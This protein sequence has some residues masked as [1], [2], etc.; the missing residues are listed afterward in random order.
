MKDDFRHEW[1]VF[2][3]TTEQYFDDG[4]PL[5]SDNMAP[6]DDG[7]PA[8]NFESSTDLQTAE[9]ATQMWLNEKKNE[10]AAWATSA[11]VFDK[12]KLPG[13]IGQIV[14]EY[15]TY[16]E[17]DPVAV[18][19]TIM[20]QLSALLSYEG[21]PF[22][23]VNNRPMRPNLYTLILGDTALGRKGTSYENAQQLMSM[24]P[25][26]TI[27]HNGVDSGEG[28]IS[29]LS[30]AEDETHEDMQ[31]TKQVFVHF[32][33]Y[34]TFMGKGRAEGSTLHNHLRTAWSGKSL[35]N[36]TRDK[37]L[38]ARDYSLSVVGH[39]TYRELRNLLG[40][41]DIYGGSLNRNILVHS[42]RSKKLPN[43]PYL[44]R[45]LLALWQTEINGA[46]NRAMNLPVVLD[47]YPIVRSDA[48]S[49]AWVKIYEDDS[50]N[51]ETEAVRAATN[52]ILVQEQKMQLLL[53]VLDGRKEISA[54]D[55]NN[56]H[57]LMVYGLET[58]RFLFN[59]VEVQSLNPAQRKMLEALREAG[60]KG[61][62]QTEITRGVFKGNMKSQA[63][64]AHLDPLIKMGHVTKQSVRTQGATKHVFRAT[65]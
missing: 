1:D 43:P 35:Q 62:T 38:E 20:T 12:E 4:T 41:N 23:M 59:P 7:D 39:A 55:V 64:K 25:I 42:H 28:L 65:T 63:I 13:A 44:E 15:D 9:D 17:A 16:T 61:M 26:A 40:E 11:P 37:K 19:M 10:A 32:D 34:A 3:D 33:E 45:D 2:G 18:F 8:A 31:K 50:A 30:H 29:L 36:K 48:A 58:A 49:R 21:G 54:E 60:E 56:A 53:A 14:R 22:L 24:T 57:M 27:T 47:G 51:E 6:V 5:P 52:R 46:L